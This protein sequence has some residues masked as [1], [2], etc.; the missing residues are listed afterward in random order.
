MKAIE[1]DNNFVEK[2]SNLIYSE[3]RNL[4]IHNQDTIDDI[5]GNTIIRIMETS[6]NYEEGKG[7]VTTWLTYQTRSVISNYFKEKKRSEDALDMTADFP[8]QVDWLD[9]GLDEEDSVE[10][11]RQTG[12]AYDMIFESGLSD[13]DKKLAYD[14]YIAG[15]TM[16]ECAKQRGRDFMTIKRKLDKIIEVLRKEYEE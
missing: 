4:G 11:E 10:D 13:E 9:L 1:I 5:F 14:Y 15:F 3:I 6:K 12:L 7:A 2:Y 8:E 16:D